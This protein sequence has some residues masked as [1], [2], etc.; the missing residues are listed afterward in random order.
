MPQSRQGVVL[1]EDADPGAL[2]RTAAR[3]DSPDGRGQTTDGMLHPV[4]VRGDG[5]SDPPA[6]LHLLKGQLGGHVNAVAEVED[7]LAVPPDGLRDAALGIA[8]R[9]RRVE[10][11]QRRTRRLA[12]RGHTRI[13]SRRYEVSDSQPVRVTRTVSLRPA[14][15][16]NGS[17]RTI[18]RWNVMFSRRTV[19]SSSRRLAM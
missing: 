6:R 18:G 7:R 3:E 5:L 12:W 14:P 1:G 15:A 2:P 13:S 9:L 8:E 11:R 17:N 10:R 16:T 4:A 19:G